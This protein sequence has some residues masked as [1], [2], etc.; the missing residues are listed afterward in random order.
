[1]E[2]KCG[3]GGFMTVDEIDQVNLRKGYVFCK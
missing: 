3:K 1:M 2:C